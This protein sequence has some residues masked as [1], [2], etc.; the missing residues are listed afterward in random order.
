[1]VTEG[2]NWSLAVV[3]RSRRRQRCRR[4]ALFAEA[5]VVRSQ[6]Q[7]SEPVFGFRPLWQSIDFNVWTERKRVEKL[8][9]LHRNP[10][11]RGL[12][13]SPEDWA[14]GSFRHYVTGE[15][16]PVEIESHWMARKREK[17]GVVP[18]VRLRHS[19]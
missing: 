19:E 6:L 2:G 17:L 11:N 10:V 8:R 18:K 15:D 7:V 13:I 9:Y 14:W 16:G 1:M 5:G 12:V 4:P 3:G